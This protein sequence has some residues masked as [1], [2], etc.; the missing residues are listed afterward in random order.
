M[1][2]NKIKQHYNNE[3]KEHAFSAKS[4]MEDLFVRDLEI[5]KIEN[6]L[7]KIVEQNQSESVLEIGCGN[8]YTVNELAKKFQCRFTAIDANEK[9]INVARKRKLKNVNFFV[10]DVLKMN[11]DEEAFDIVFSERCLINL[12][13]WTAQRKALSMIHKILRKGGHYVMLEAFNDGLNELNKARKSLGL[14]K[15]NPAWHN[16]YF[17]KKKLESHIKGKFTDWNN[18]LELHMTIF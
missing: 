2:P 17:D 12:T 14:K 16:L 1:N 11:F 7:E 18:N 3:V 5:S 8:G 13:S 10:R 4:T 9:M 15:I 6:V